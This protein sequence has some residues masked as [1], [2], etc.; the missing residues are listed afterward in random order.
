MTEEQEIMF[1]FKVYHY[2]SMI[3]KTSTN[4]ILNHKTQFSDSL[5]DIFKQVEI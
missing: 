3:D 4:K 2:F 5:S 1:F